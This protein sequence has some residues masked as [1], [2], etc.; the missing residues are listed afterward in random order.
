MWI[1]F[2]YTDIPPA[3]PGI[4]QQEKFCIFKISK[5]SLCPH[6]IV[7]YDEMAEIIKNE[8]ST[9]NRKKGK[10]VNFEKRSSLFFKLIQCLIKFHISGSSDDG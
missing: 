3:S 5:Y 9:K 7:L 4:F 8:K 10:N 6:F 1:I 2:L